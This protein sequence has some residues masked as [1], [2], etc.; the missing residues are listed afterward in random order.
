MTR[1]SSIFLLT[2]GV[3]VLTLIRESK[4]VSWE[5]WWTYDGISGPAFWG[6]INPEWSLCNKGRRQSPVNLEPAR[7][8]F[9]PNLRSL[10]LDKHRI[11]GI[12]ANTGHSVVFAVDNDTRHPVN[13]SGGPLSYR[14]QFHE[15]HLHYGLHDRTGSE[16]TVDGYAFP[17]EIQIFGFNSQLYNNFSDALHRAQG[18]V[19]VS[20]LLQLGDLSNPE[21]RIFTEQLDKI[22]YGGEATEIK[23]LA[24]RGLLPGTEHYMT[25]D[26]ST[27][28]P[29]C[30]ETTTWIILNKP[31]YITKQQLHAL[32]KLMQGDQK[33][34]KAPLGNNFR[35][36][37][38]LH[39]R[40]VRTNIDFNVQPTVGSSPEQY[41]FPLF[42]QADEHRQ[43]CNFLIFA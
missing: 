10:H 3:F 11:G 41:G 38:P 19:A 12:L 14:Y 33:R 27:T 15:I 5:E 28:M 6:L 39:H 18:I 31:I 22:K 9:D 36:P 4:P 35:P 2:S 26:G 34:P 13:I 29:A 37:Q 21:L 1:I 42:S 7:L 25:Y 32:R 24:V 23:R 16:H 17:A 40:P 20:L 43:I 8:L 30:H